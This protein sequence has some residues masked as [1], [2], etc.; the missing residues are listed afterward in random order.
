MKDKNWKTIP[1][2]GGIQGLTGNVGKDFVLPPPEKKGPKLKNYYKNVIERG[3]ELVLSPDNDITDA[4]KA[5]RYLLSEMTNPAD[6]KSKITTA[7]RAIRERLKELEI[8]S[9]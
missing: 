9:S 4:T 1:L 5:A 2:P 7:A 3:V 6:V 8:A